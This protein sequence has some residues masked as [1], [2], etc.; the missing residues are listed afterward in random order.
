MADEIL[1]YTSPV[2]SF[3]RDVTTDVEVGGVH[4]E[5]GERVLMIHPSGNRDGRVF[6]DPDRLDLAR[7]PNPHIAFGGGEPHYC[8]GAN[9]AKREIRVLFE[10]LADRW[11]SFEPTGSAEW[12]GPGPRNNVG[13]SLTRL[14]VAMA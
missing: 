7:D 10:C 6:A 5:E 9:L 8:L 11:K 3:A 12:A 14:P 13:M 2:I 4:I 1:R